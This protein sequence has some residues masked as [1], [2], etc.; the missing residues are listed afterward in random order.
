MHFIIRQAQRPHGDL[1]YY[2]SKRLTLQFRFWYD[3]DL[4][5]FFLRFSLVFNLRESF[6]TSY[7]IFIWRNSLHARLNRHCNAYSYKKEKYKKI[8]V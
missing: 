6:A 3:F 7:F 8:K 1:M 5:D 4:P 2:T